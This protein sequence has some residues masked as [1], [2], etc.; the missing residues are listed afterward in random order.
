MCDEGQ[1]GMLS[2]D[3]TNPNELIPDLYAMQAALQLKNYGRPVSFSRF[4]ARW[5]MRRSAVFWRG[6]TTGFQPGG[7]ISNVQRLASNTRVKICMQQRHF[8]NID[9]KISRV[10]QTDSAF[11]TQAKAWLKNEGILTPPVPESTFAR[12]RY[13]PD[14]PGN[15]MAWG[16]ILKYL[17]GCLVLRAPQERSLYYYKLMQPGKHYFPV[18]EDFSDMESTLE[19]AEMHSEQAA[20][21]AWCGHRMAHRYL[22]QVGNNFCDASLAHIELL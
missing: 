11:T 10:V 5:Q 17:C 16:T 19:W 12:Y 21:I 20:W 1:P 8:S 22:Q 13:Y 2:M 14:L 9:M 18:Q 6:S 7:L 15:A 3:G 4:L